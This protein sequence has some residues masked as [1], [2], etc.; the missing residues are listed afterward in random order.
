MGLLDLPAEV[1]Q[2]LGRNP[3]GLVVIK[4]FSIDDIRIVKPGNLEPLGE[5]RVDKFR[6]AVSP[7]IGVAYDIALAVQNGDI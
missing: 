7:E 1:Q 6:A 3:D 5:N 2:Q 4:R